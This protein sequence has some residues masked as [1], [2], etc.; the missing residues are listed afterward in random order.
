MK[1]LSLLDLP[2]GSG[3]DPDGPSFWWSLRYKPMYERAVTDF[4]GL[5]EVMPIFFL[6]WP[7]HQVY[8]TDPGQALIVDKMTGLLKESG[9]RKLWEVDYRAARAFRPQ[10]VAPQISE[11]LSGTASRSSW[12]P[13]VMAEVKVPA[14]SVEEVIAKLSSLN[15]FS[16]HWPA[17]Q[18]DCMFRVFC[19]PELLESLRY[20]WCVASNFSGTPSRIW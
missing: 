9:K 19:E 20:G 8:L 5:Y 16:Q 3:Q 13:M 1:Q 10:D 18:E 17:F 14:A 11:I 4:F 15:V 6:E 12:R 2:A 7:R